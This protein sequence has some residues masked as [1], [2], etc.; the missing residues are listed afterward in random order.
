MPEIMDGKNIFDFVDPEIDQKLQELEDEEDQIME[1]L[2]NEKAFEGDNKGG[3]DDEDISLDEDL[4][5][6][7]GK[8]MKNK[9]SMRKNHQLVVASQLPKKVRGLTETEELM[10]KIRWDKGDLKDKFLTQKSL[11]QEH[12]KKR[13]N[14]MSVKNSLIQ[15]KLGD[16]EDIDVDMNLEDED[17]EEKVKNLEKRKKD[18]AQKKLVVERLKRKIQKKLNRDAKVDTADRRIQSKLPKHLNSGHRGIG[19]TDYR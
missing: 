18:D 6:A 2:Y 14:S 5:E 19:K 8:M 13:K 3:D 4:I 11:R 9:E 12:I 15:S 10:Q 17:Y 7:H 16:E 1:K